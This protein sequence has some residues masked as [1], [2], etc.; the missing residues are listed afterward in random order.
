MN[1]ELYDKPGLIIQND[2]ITR[3]TKVKK[4]VSK[5]KPLDYKILYLENPSGDFREIERELKNLEDSYLGKNIPKKEK[6]V[7]VASKPRYEY[8][9]NCNTVLIAYNDEQLALLK[10]WYNI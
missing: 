8:R 5:N 2:A 1:N 7:F 4:W 10:A 9:L 6:E 3:T